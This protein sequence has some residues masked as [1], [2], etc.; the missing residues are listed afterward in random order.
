MKQLRVEPT[1]GLM[2][3]P[4]SD[5]ATTG[6]PLFPGGGAPVVAS[7]LVVACIVYAPERLEDLAQIL[8]GV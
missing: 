1:D 8:L 2:P 3:S 7:L 6:A 5:H 4:T